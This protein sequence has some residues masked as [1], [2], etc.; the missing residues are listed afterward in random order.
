MATP[1]DAKAKAATTY[2]AADDYYDNPANSFGNGSVVRQS[3]VSDSLWAHVCS[4]C[5]AAVERLLCPRPRW[6]GQKDPFWASTSQQTYLNLRQRRRQ[7][8]A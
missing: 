6:L 8:A 3:S 5:A 7:S 4:M 1:N 2:N